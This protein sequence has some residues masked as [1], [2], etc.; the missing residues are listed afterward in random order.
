MREYIDRDLTSRAAGK[1][2]R[3]YGVRLPRVGYEV[4]LG[5]GLWIASTGHA[6]FGW[7]ESR[8]KTP[9][10]LRGTKED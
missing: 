6:Q 1:L 5:N 7:F 8:A 3:E 10:R 4:S 9:Y 2:A